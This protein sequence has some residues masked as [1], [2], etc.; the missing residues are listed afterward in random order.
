[1]TGCLLMMLWTQ[2]P[3]ELFRD[4]THQNSLGK[5][6]SDGF[7]FFRSRQTAL[8]HLRYRRGNTTH[9]REPEAGSGRRAPPGC[10]P[11]L[12]SPGDTAPPTALPGAPVFTPVLAYCRGPTPT[13]GP[14]QASSRLPGEGP[15]VSW[16]PLARQDLRCP[17]RGW[18]DRPELSTPEARGSVAPQRTTIN[19]LER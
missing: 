15:A 19:L 5:L 7:S 3:A 18:G 10:A 1:M 4:K 17:H 2:K 14:R 11:R 6:D 16:R 13:P 9:C 12:E 8:Y